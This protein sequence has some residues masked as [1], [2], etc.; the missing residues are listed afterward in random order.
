MTDVVVSPST[1]ALVEDYARHAAEKEARIAGLLEAAGL[2]GLF[3]GLRRCPVELG[4]RAQASFYVDR[5][6]GGAAVLGVDPRRGRVPVD[7]ALWVVPDF[8][9]ERVR[10][11]AERVAAEPAA[12]GVTGFD[13]RLEYGGGRA[14]LGLFVERTASG[15]LGPLCA[16]LLALP[17]VLG[18]AAVSHGVEMGETE[19]RHQLLGK[20][21]L[22]HHRAFFQ[23]NARLTPELAAATHAAAADPSS[24]LDLYCGVGPHSILAAAPESRVLGLETNRHSIESA[25]RNAALHGLAHARYERE[26]VERLIGG[27]APEPPSIAYVNPSRFG[28]APGLPAAVARWRPAAVCLIS[29]SADSHV[30]D[31]LAFMAAGYRPMPFGSFDMFPFSPFAESVTVFHPRT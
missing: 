23:T 14:H 31:T 15:D 25:R 28:C 26:P 21:V 2:G 7:E 30:R 9:R 27:A 3:A 12:S 8:A 16:D 4:Y 10:A 11:A 1:D 22:A 18:V 13:A 17:G 5:S 29:C 6:R 19:L 20:T 24:I